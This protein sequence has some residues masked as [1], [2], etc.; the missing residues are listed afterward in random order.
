MYWIDLIVDNS[1]NIRNKSQVT[2]LYFESEERKAR[3]KDY[4]QAR[5]VRKKMSN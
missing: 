2:L 3:K 4:I 1:F 5:V